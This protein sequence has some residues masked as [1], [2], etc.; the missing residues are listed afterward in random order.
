MNVWGSGCVMTERE[1]EIGLWIDSTF[2]S[3]S[4]HQNYSYWNKWVSEWNGV[5]V[6]DRERKIGLWVESIFSSK[7]VHQITHPEMSE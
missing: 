6:R 4:V 3:K 2:S 5:F 7:S 1:R